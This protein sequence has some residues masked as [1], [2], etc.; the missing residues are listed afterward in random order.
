MKQKKIFL[1][2]VFALVLSVILIAG[3]LPVLP[4]CSEKSASAS[5]FQYV[6]PEKISGKLDNPG[7]GWVFNEDSVFYG[8]LDLG[9]SGEMPDCDIVYIGT[10]WAL[11][12][13][14]EGVFDFSIIDQAMDYWRPRGKKF[15]FK[16]S[17][18]SF[19]LPNTYTGAPTWLIEKYNIPY[20]TFDYT[21]G[22]PVPKFIAYDVTNEVYL[23]FLDRFLGKLYEKYGNDDAVETIEIRGYGNWGEW[24]TG[25]VFENR[26]IKRAALEN[27]IDKY[28]AAFKES[29]KIMVLCCSWDP[30][31]LPYYGLEN[32][33][34]NY[35]TWN[36]YDY[37]YKI[38]NVSFRRDGIAGALYYA[39]DQKFMSEV[40][41]SGKRLPLFGEYAGTSADAISGSGSYSLLD[42]INEG[43]YKL[44]LNYCT[45]IDWTAEQVAWLIENGYREVFDRGNEMMGYRLAV[46]MARFPKTAKA[47]DPIE[48]L[49]QWSNSAVGRFFYDYKLALY[50]L[51]ANDNIISTT[52]NSEFD[53]TNFTQ[54]EITNIYSELEIPAD[55][56]FGEY[57]VAVGIV[58]DEGEAAIELGMGG[59]LEDARIYRLGNI[60]VGEESVEGSL[61]EKMSWDEFQN[62]S[63]TPY[64]TY[65]VTLRYTPA[66]SIEDYTFDN[67][68]GYVFKLTS[69]KGGPSATAGWTKWQDVSETTCFKTFTFTVGQF[70]DYK[71][72]LES[73]NFGDISVSDV[74]VEKM[75]GMLE[76]FEG[77]ADGNADLISMEENFTTSLAQNGTIT[78]RD[79]SMNDGENNVISGDKS[80]LVQASGDGA[81]Y[82]IYTNQYNFK[83][84]PNTTYTLSFNFRSKVGTDV[85][86]GGYYV[87]D[88]YNSAEESYAKIGEWYERSDNYVTT[89]TFTFNTGSEGYDSFAFGVVNSGSFLIDNLIL[90]EHSSGEIVDGEDIEYV[91]N[92]RRESEGGLDVTEGFESGT[93][94]GSNFTRGVNNLAKLTNDE[95]LV[96]S[97]DWSLFACYE[98]A[99]YSSLY[100]GVGETNP[101]YFSFKPGGTY[102]VQFKYRIIDAPAG[103]SF[104]AFFRDPTTPNTIE[105]DLQAYLYAGDASKGDLKTEEVTPEEGNPYTQ[106]DWTITLMDEYEGNPLENYQFYFGV[107]G[108]MI[109]VID[110]ILITE[111]V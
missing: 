15:H 109:V 31:E 66:M 101:L 46:D 2:K 59:K 45:V 83:L 57:T 104:Y 82:G 67:W 88:M 111:V 100:F 54:G 62:Y 50:L 41:R 10:T 42:G 102:R 9:A 74:Y 75:Y 63:F 29:D 23:K 107:T 81:Q 76:N 13:Q 80:V 3:I 91:Q 5:D 84:K 12:E 110:D 47:G 40:F 55:I 61:T 24:H 34:R 27:I 19:M 52:I 48:V 85:G 35:Y 4:G 58:N 108:Y 20:Q 79:D 36:A 32:P 43:L 73:E 68:N 28:V 18:D 77:Y 7:M 21:N 14:E 22:G 6:Y 65:Q 16:I 87:V 8:G 93:I 64:A 30:N 71:A 25:Y 69:E 86:N 11:I 103:T 98:K 49:T 90:I 60:T 89:K 97:G 105:A 70:D 33:Y 94:I 92:V 96:I 26:D 51:D 39:Y 53:A 38:D 17:T 95:D 37:A 106:V 99:N 72:V 56:S 1:N 44:R 78:Y